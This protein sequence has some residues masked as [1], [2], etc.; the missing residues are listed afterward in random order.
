MYWSQQQSPPLDLLEAAHGL[1]PVGFG[2]S[3]DLSVA[4]ALQTHRRDKGRISALQGN[5]KLVPST[6]LGR[7]HK[8]R[9]N[10]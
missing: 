4:A 6:L 5:T 1:S 10:G 3:G 9:H 2:V 8:H 7:I